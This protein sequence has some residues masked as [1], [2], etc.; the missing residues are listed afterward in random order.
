MHVDDQSWG[1]ALTATNK[2]D[3]DNV[4]N[5]ELSLKHAGVKIRKQTPETEACTSSKK[6]AIAADESTAE[7][8]TAGANDDSKNKN[9]N[10]GATSNDDMRAAK[11]SLFPTLKEGDVVGCLLDTRVGCAHTKQAF[12]VSKHL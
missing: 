1:L 8:V 9:A 10:V 12:I 3:K 5:D 7:T 2:E 6:S 11:K 4:N